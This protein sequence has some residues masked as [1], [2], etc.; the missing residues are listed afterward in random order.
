MLLPRPGSLQPQHIPAGPTESL[1]ACQTD[2][3]RG[4]HRPGTVPAAHPGTGTGTPRNSGAST[5]HCSVCSRDG[6]SCAQGHASGAGTRAASCQQA[7]GAAGQPG[8]RVGTHGHAWLGRHTH[9]ERSLHTHAHVPTPGRSGSPRVRAGCPAQRTGALPPL[10]GRALPEGIR[11]GKPRHASATGCVT[12]HNSGS[13]GTVQPWEQAA[14]PGAAPGTVPPEAPLQ[15][16]RLGTGLGR[17]W[18]RPGPERLPR[19]SRHGPGHGWDVQPDRGRA[20]SLPM[21]VLVQT[22]AQGLRQQ[23]ATGAGVANAPSPVEGS[24]RQEAA[25]AQRDGCPGTCSGC[26]KARA[27]CCLAVP[28]PRQS[29]QAASSSLP[30][31]PAPTAPSQ[32]WPR[33]CPKVRGRVGTSCPGG[34]GPAAARGCEPCLVTGRP[35]IVPRGRTMAGELPGHH[36]P[37]HSTRWEPPPLPRQGQSHAG[38]PQPLAA[39]WPVPVPA[40]GRCSCLVAWHSKAGHS[41]ARHGTAQHGTA[42]AGLHRAQHRAAPASCL[43]MWLIRQQGG[44]RVHARMERA[45]CWGT[46]WVTG[47]S[48]QPREHLKPCPCPESGPRAARPAPPAQRHA[49]AAAAAAAGALLPLGTAAVGRWV[50]VGAGGVGVG[51]GWV[52]GEPG[53]RARWAQGAGGTVLQ[54]DL[55]K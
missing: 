32:P 43:P 21:T 55:Q 11:Q 34:A 3:P 52:R 33:C 51:A 16:P 36:G 6:S 13:A 50:M 48:L 17:V 20:V 39:S 31:A 23:A 49:P 38:V 53:V 24:G 7:C 41:R 2:G 4:W 26:S 54:K 14:A 35:A 42:C 25:P 46:G 47:T 15:I 18:D 44:D 10:P 27:Q 19:G 30:A 40:A 29:P 9:T 37:L 28:V 8:L 5:P 22:H 12:R 1:L 45:G